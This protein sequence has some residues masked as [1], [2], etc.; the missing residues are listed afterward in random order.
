[1]TTMPNLG[2]W[3]RMGMLRAGS[4]RLSLRSLVIISPASPG[5]TAGATGG[6]G[7]ASLAPPPPRDGDSVPEDD[8]E[9]EEDAARASAPP[10][11]HRASL[12]WKRRV[13]LDSLLKFV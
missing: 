8:A 4:S 1:M 3:G 11:L 6:G 5:A 9:E 10:P 7:A 2:R 12:G 13:G